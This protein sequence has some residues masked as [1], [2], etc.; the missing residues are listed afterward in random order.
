MF[1]VV[2][3]FV[4]VF[5][6]RVG[7]ILA[8]VELGRTN[9]YIKNKLKPRSHKGSKE[10]SYLMREKVTT[11]GSRVF[12]TNAP[13]LCVLCTPTFPRESASN[14]IWASMPAPGDPWR[15]KCLSVP[16]LRI[17]QSADPPVAPGSQ[18][19]P[20]LCLVSVTMPF[21]TLTPTQG[22]HGAA[23]LSCLA[24]TRKR[25]A[26]VPRQATMRIEMCDECKRDITKA[27]RNIVSRR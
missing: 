21:N 5:S 18:S 16:T 19:S 13:P 15:S 6:D 22:Y 11:H 20:V 12:P 2:S 27:F 10:I 24:M 26:K 17:H 3:L 23:M 7:T 25:P 8:W 1:D 9:S 14:P 4:C